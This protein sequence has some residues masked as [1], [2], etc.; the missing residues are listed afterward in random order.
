MG[1]DGEQHDDAAPIPSHDVTL[2]AL[3]P[4]APSG[5]SASREAAGAAPKEPCVFFDYAVGL[6]H[7]QLVRSAPGASSASMLQL[8][9]FELR[10]AGS[11]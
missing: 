8:G 1:D 2:S 9:I 3:L 10:S 6:V 4:D 7:L 11:I 5:A